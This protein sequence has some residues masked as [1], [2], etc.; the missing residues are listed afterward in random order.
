MAE[1]KIFLI[2]ISN[3]WRITEK[4][5]RTISRKLGS[6]NLNDRQKMPFQ[7]NTF[8]TFE[9]IVGYWSWNNKFFED[10]FSKWPTFKLSIDLWA[11]EFGKLLDISEDK[12]IECH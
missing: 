5:I 11:L 1:I 9:I 4:K 7:V 10:C 12:K 8:K 6:S 3:F 2:N